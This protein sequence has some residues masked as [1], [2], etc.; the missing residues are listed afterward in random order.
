MGKE[1]P[2]EEVLANFP[3]FPKGYKTEG[4]STP[5][6]A[7]ALMKAMSGLKDISLGKIPVRKRRCLPAKVQIM[8]QLKKWTLDFY[9]EMARKEDE[10]RN[11][12]ICKVLEE[13]ARYE[14]EQKT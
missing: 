2:I 10:S 14:M 5:E 1:K 8:L 12:A 9:T 11:R 6:E 7:I 13:Y 4:G 3:G